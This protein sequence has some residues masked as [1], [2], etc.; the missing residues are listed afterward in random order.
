MQQL[1]L[2]NRAIDDCTKHGKTHL[3]FVLFH[4]YF[5]AAGNKIKRMLKEAII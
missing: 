5:I 4:I 3:F 2:V 1:C